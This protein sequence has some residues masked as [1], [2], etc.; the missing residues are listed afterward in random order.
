MYEWK[1]FLGKSWISVLDKLG[2]ILQLISSLFKTMK[3]V[4][5]LKTFSTID[6]L[7]GETEKFN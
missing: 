5:N 3:S 6:F 1:E 4:L 2:I 7:S